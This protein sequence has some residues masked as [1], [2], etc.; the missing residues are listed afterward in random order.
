MIVDDED[1]ESDVIF[2]E[3][4]GDFF[5]KKDKKQIIVRSCEIQCDLDDDIGVFLKSFGNLFV[6]RNLEFKNK[7][8]DD[9]IVEMDISKS[10]IFK[11]DFLGVE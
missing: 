8:S 9:K 11:L 7:K 3:K 4:T 10:V 5:N 6:F 2:C 1:L